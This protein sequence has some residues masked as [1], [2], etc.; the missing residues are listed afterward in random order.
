MRPDGKGMP[1]EDMVVAFV[2]ECIE[3]LLD[4]FK[5]KQARVR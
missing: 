1:F 3:P 5:A 4:N 2:G